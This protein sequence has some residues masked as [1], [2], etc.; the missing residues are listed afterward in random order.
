MF[1]FGR[2]HEKKCEARYVRNAEQIHLLMAI[3]DAVHDLIE[4]TGSESQ[5][6]DAIRAGF[7]QGGSGVWESAAR[8]LRKSSADYP[9]VLQLWLE[10]ASHSNALIRFRAACF[11]DEMPQGIYATV[12]TALLADRSKKVTSMAA[13]RISERGE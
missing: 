10:F 8:W 7:T 1:T 6:I 3:I 4:G 11:L 5:L 2:E 12:A 13:D 9:S